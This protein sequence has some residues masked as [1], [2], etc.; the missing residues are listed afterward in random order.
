MKYKKA[1]KKFLKMCDETIDKE[2]RKGLSGVSR[3]GTSSVTVAVVKKLSGEQIVKWLGSIP[4][5]NPEE[6]SD[7]LV[8]PKGRLL[9]WHSF[10]STEKGTTLCFTHELPLALSDK[11]AATTSSLSLFLYNL[12]VE[13]ERDERV[14]PYDEWLDICV[15]DK[16]RELDPKTLRKDVKKFFRLKKSLRKS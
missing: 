11:V 10:T 15:L 8:T 12:Y 13:R 16:L 4:R 6:G 5:Y 14:P 1:C 2:Y 3:I 9:H 7:G